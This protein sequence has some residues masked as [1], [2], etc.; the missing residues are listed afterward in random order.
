MQNKA[1]SAVIRE[2]IATLLTEGSLHSVVGGNDA[3]PGL[4]LLMIMNHNKGEDKPLLLSYASNPAHPGVSSPRVDAHYGLPATFRNY[5]QQAEKWSPT[6]MSMR[7]KGHLQL[8]FPCSRSKT[9]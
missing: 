1:L 2:I 8:F 3:P 9:D 7:P 6:L 5:T 4:S